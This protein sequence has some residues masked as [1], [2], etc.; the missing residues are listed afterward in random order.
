MMC[1]SLLCL[2]V[3]WLDKQTFNPTSVVEHQTK[4][5]NGY[6]LQTWQA[7]YYLFICCYHMLL[8]ILRISYLVCQLC[9][10]TQYNFKHDNFNFLIDVKYF[11]ETVLKTQ[12]LTIVVSL[13]HLI[14]RQVT[15]NLIFQ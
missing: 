3:L 2:S 13:W 9:L 10:I 5:S 6:W 15:K 12:L 1:T 8:D 14:C 7:S 4:A 11:T